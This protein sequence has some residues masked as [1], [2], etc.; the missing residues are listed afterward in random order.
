MTGESIVDG[1]LQDRRLV[2]HGLLKQKLC[3]IDRV[4]VFEDPKQYIDHVD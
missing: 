3:Q 4:V 1:C 2:E